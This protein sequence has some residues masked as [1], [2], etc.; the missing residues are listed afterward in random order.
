VVAA[1]LKSAMDSILVIYHQHN[2][3]EIIQVNYG[4]SGKLYEQ[5]QN[6]A[7]FDVFFA[8]NL[9]YPNKLKASGFGVSKVKTYAVGKLAIWSKK[10]DPN[11]AQM[12]S[13]LDASIKKIAVANPVTA[14]YGTKA[15]ESLK[16]FKLY[17]KIENKLVYGDNIA[18]TAQF[19]AF[20][21]ADIGIIALSDA[22]SPKMKKEGGKFY[23]IPES[24]YSPLEQGCVILKHGISNPLAT[25]FYDFI[26]TEK[27]IGILTYYGYSQ[28][29][30]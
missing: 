2:P 8:A 1:N 26:S 23:I 18:Q 22:L 12:N 29:T 13:L 3:G 15:V 21:A 11:T 6:G 20:G 5:I 7:P 25:K 14:P 4:S 17:R 10:M 30:K 9:N 28:K 19:V 24:S 16:H 27:V